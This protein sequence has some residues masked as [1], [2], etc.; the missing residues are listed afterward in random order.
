MY[1]VQQLWSPPAMRSQRVKS[2]TNKS[3]LSQD[4]RFEVLKDSTPENLGTAL[5][6]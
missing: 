5:N 3:L 6:T 4:V 2:A 1:A